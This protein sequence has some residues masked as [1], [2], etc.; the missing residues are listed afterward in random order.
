MLKA[1]QIGAC[2]VFNASFD[3]FPNARGQ[4]EG[5]GD[6]QQFIGIW[7][8]GWLCPKVRDE[9]GATPPANA[10]LWIDFW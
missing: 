7:V 9:Q 10:S 5:E 2:V 4:H 1:L 8:A 6:A 3:F